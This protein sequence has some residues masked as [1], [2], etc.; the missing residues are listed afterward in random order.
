L[1]AIRVHRALLF[2][3]LADT[4]EPRLQCKLVRGAHG[5]HLHAWIQIQLLDTEF[6]L[7]LLN[8]PGMLMAYGSRAAQR[9]VRL[10]QS[11]DTHRAIG[12]FVRTMNGC[13]MSVCMGDMYHLRLGQSDN[14]RVNNDVYLCAMYVCNMYVCMGGGSCVCMCSLV[15]YN[16]CSCDV[17][18]MIYV[19]VPYVCNALFVYMRYA[20]SVLFVYMRCTRY[21]IRVYLP[22]VS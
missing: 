10:G 14:L 20:C 15:R 8:R 7:E 3:T 13:N 4:L 19:Y 11:L 18:G 22:C 1:C 2:K 9:Y 16:V 5:D 6:V 12:V 17:R 21:D